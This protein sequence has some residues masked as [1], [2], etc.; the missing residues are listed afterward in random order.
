MRFIWL[1]KSK[2][3][4][5]KSVHSLF[6]DMGEI[7]ELQV[8]L[9]TVTSCLALYDV[10]KQHQTS[11][12]PQNHIKGHELSLGYAGM[13]LVRENIIFL[14]FNNHVKFLIQSL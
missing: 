12:E 8:E 6:F 14:C 11:N 10:G 9:H 3:I 7:C 2:A 1:L 5:G 4:G 13:A